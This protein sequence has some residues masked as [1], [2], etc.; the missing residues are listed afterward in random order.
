MADNYLQFS[1]QIVIKGGKK[2]VDTLTREL[3]LIDERAIDEDD[4]QWDEYV[5]LCSIYGMDPGYSCLDFGYEFK[6]EG[7]R[8]TLWVYAGEY[9]S[10][11]NVCIFMKRY[12]K[13]FNPDRCFSISWATSCSKPRI[14][15]FGGGAAFVTKDEIIWL[16]THQWLETNFK[17]FDEKKSA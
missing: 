17:Q 3:E 11:D 1:E 5:A 13:R 8:W 12:L 4:P 15:E 9:G 6:K 16:S 7:R 2:A 14:G 10:I